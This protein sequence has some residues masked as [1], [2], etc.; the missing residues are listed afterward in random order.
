VGCSANEEEEGVKDTNCAVYELDS[1][2]RGT[3]TVAAS[4]ERS[5]TAQSHLL[6]IWYQVKYA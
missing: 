5:H 3:L 1:F 6:C 2:R 4:C